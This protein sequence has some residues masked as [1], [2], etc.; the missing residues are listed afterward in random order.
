MADLYAIDELGLG[1]CREKEAEEL[2]LQGSAENGARQAFSQ[3]AMVCWRG[4]GNLAILV[5]KPSAKQMAE[6]L[7]DA[8][9]HYAGKHNSA[10][11]AAAVLTS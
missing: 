7:E 3:I 1:T 8:I 6:K 5:D 9:Q 10:S 11:K 4:R 2:G